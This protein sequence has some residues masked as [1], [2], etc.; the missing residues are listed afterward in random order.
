MT[1]KV[2]FYFIWK[3]FKGYSAFYFTKTELAAKLIAAL[4]KDSRQFRDA[5]SETTCQTVYAIPITGSYFLLSN[6]PLSGEKLFFPSI[7]IILRVIQ[8][9]LSPPSN[10][11]FTL[12]EH[13]PIGSYSNSIYWKEAVRWKTKIIP[14]RGLQRS[15]TKKVCTQPIG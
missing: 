8:V 6:F 3:C 9:D 15:T 12:G 2:W 4:F 14:D 1:K 11:S 7:H 10:K 5:S 13:S